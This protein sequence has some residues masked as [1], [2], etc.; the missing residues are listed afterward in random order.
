MTA[1]INGLSLDE[2]TGRVILEDSPGIYDWMGLPFDKNN[3]SAGET[4]GTIVSVSYR[5]GVD[6][7]NEIV[8]QDVSVTPYAGQ[9]FVSGGLPMKADGTILIDTV[10]EIKNYYQR[11]PLT[12]SGALAVMPMGPV[13]VKPT[14]P[15][16]LHELGVTADDMGSYDFVASTIDPP[17]TIKGYRA[18]DGT[19]T[20]DVATSDSAGGKLKYTWQYA[21]ASNSYKMSVAAVSSDGVVSD[22]SAQL[23]VVTYP[24][25]PVIISAVGGVNKI[26]VQFKSGPKNGNMP[27]SSYNYFVTNPAN[28][29]IS[30]ALYYKDI[31]GGVI[32]GVVEIIDPEFCVDGLKL[33]LDARNVAGA[34]YNTSPVIVNGVTDG[35]I[36]LAPSLD[37]AFPASTSVVLAYTYTDTR[38]TL[39][40]EPVFYTGYASDGTNTFKREVY[41][42]DQDL[43]VYG[44]ANGVKYDCWVTATSAEGKEGPKSNV[45]SATTGTQIPA[46]VVQGI[47]AGDG[48][49]TATFS[50]VTP[51]QKWTVA[52][53][54]FLAVNMDNPDAPELEGYCMSGIPFALPNNTNW[55]VSI[56]AVCNPGLVPG[57]FSAPIKVS[58]EAPSVPYRPVITNCYFQPNGQMVIEWVKGVNGANRNSSAMDVTSWQL[59]VLTGDGKGTSQILDIKDP[60]TTK[61][62]T[63]KLTIGWWEVIVYAVNDQGRSDGSKPISVQ[64]NPTKDDPILGGTRFDDG[65]Y[66]Y[67][68]FNSGATTGY[69]AVRTDAGKNIDFEVIL[70]G[71]GGS[72]KGVTLVGGKGGDGG[73]GQM[74]IG[75]LPATGNT[76][77][78]KISVPKGG[79]SAGAVVDNTTVTETTTTL[80]AVAGKSASDKNN[81]D[82]YQKQAV[83]NGWNT[84]PEFTWL[85]PITD[86]VGGVASQGEQNYPNATNCGEGGA[87][88]KVNAPGRGGDSFVAIRWKK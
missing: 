36:P 67:A 62:L 32:E 40:L 46:P 4:G 57:D 27:I 16:G 17:A 8:C 25:P 2:A 26:T 18:S 41:D 1:Y 39:G 74:V 6:A 7:N 66:K 22:S 33:Q 11:L 14:A 52:H 59:N 54:S 81:A 21:N 78:I 20:K 29:R 50:A 80:T 44:L 49:A 3:L 88:T 63:D 45:I 83:P 70:C 12:L 13:P 64:Y 86:Y 79:V 38:G 37:G 72:G 69:E 31:G 73:G 76:T 43:V 58:P 30:N 19:Q 68:M 28:K 75:L 24:D 23:N 61:Y 55:N 51:D 84:L 87:G 60:A 85:H 35:S 5:G 15:T 10:G 77:S 42:P 65:T 34:S 82:G 48:V 9:I 47:V 71:A 53:Y 56:C